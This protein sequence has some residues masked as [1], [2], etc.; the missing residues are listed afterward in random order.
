MSYIKTFT[1][2]V[3]QLRLI[4]LLSA[5]IIFAEMISEWQAS[6]VLLH[7]T[8]ICILVMERYYRVKTLTADT[9]LI[10]EPAK[11]LLRPDFHIC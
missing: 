6:L 11:V 2:M 5:K 9:S 10:S 8:C 7:L 4:L 3:L 1:L